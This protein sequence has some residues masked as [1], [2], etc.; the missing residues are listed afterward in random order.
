MSVDEILERVRALCLALP[1]IEERPSHGAP[2]W[3]VR[4]KK[5][6]AA[7][8]DHHHGVDQVAVWCPAPEGA[9]AAM[10][11]MDPGRFFVPPYVGPRGWIGVRL[12]D[13]TD[14]DELGQIL[15]D[16]FRCV[17]PRRALAEL[18]AALKGPG[19]GTS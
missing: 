8:D 10:V 11:E 5:Q 13:D 2:C 18:D 12:D 15:E 17:A 14:W 6:L 19:A 3:F 7:F 16:A 4:G 9:Q 1:G